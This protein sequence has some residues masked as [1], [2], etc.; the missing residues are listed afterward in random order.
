MSIQLSPYHK[1]SSPHDT[2]VLKFPYGSFRETF[3]IGS[4]IANKIRYFNPNVTS[5]LSD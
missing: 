5:T 1:G 3:E 4:M 2:I